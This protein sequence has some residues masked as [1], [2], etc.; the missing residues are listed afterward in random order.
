MMSY[1]DPGGT[2]TWAWVQSDTGRESAFTR[3]RHVI[4][5]YDPYGQMGTT[6]CDKPFRE[7]W[8]EKTDKDIAESL[9]RDGIPP[10]L[11]PKCDRATRKDTDHG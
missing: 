11:C 3:V 1:L 5:E 8:G 10:E 7:P 2:R 6:A 9:E 4:R